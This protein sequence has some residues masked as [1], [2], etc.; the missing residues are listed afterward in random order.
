MIR[1]AK[2]PTEPRAHTGLRL[3]RREGGSP[4]GVGLSFLVHPEEFKG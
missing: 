3:I 4:Q 2:L 1:W